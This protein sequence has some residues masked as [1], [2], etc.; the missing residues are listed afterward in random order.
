MPIRVANRANVLHNN[1]CA[2]MSI[3][4]PSASFASSCSAN[5]AAALGTLTETSL[6]YEDLIGNIAI[7]A[8]HETATVDPWQHILA[9]GDAATGVHLT[10][11]GRCTT[12]ALGG[13]IWLSVHRPVY[14][15]LA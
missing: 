4:S 3:C 11:A 14:L 8:S 6:V 10:A 7:S 2:P 9:V 13:S 12:L 15:L 5:T 1:A